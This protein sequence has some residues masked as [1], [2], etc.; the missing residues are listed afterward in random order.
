MNLDVQ[1]TLAYLCIVQVI[2]AVVY[3][4]LTAGMDTPFKN[5]ILQY[6]H[7]VAIKKGSATKRRNLYLLGLA[8]GLVAVALWRPFHPEGRGGGKRS[9]S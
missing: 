6:P 4:V 5:A 2:A 1:S 7:L 8:V 9:P 3:L